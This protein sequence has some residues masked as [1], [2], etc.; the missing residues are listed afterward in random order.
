MGGG[1][2]ELQAAA[3][4][5]AF[6]VETDLSFGLGVVLGSETHIISSGSENS[7]MRGKTNGEP[8]MVRAHTRP[9][10]VK[11]WSQEAN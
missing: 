3:S 6:V 5:A 4:A 9:S 8:R 2:R 7:E 10:L 11:C 1:E